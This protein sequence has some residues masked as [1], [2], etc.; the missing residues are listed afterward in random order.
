MKQFLVTYTYQPGVG[1]KYWFKFH[2]FSAMSIPIKS[3]Q[4]ALK[5]AN[6]VIHDCE[7]CGWTDSVSV[8]KLK[9]TLE[10]RKESCFGTYYKEYQEIQLYGRRGQNVGTLLHELAH[11]MDETH[12]DEFRSWF[13]KLMSAWI[14]LVEVSPEFLEWKRYGC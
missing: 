13:G 10:P 5:V 7:N 12:G 4:F 14:A 9:I 3:S 2:W 8:R 11:V 6:A 1:E